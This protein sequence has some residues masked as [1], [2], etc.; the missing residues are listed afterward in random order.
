MLKAIMKEA[1]NLASLEEFRSSKEDADVLSS[2]G[3]FHMSDSAGD[4]TCCLTTLYPCLAVAL[5]LALPG[6]SGSS[7]AAAL[8]RLSVRYKHHLHSQ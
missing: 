8:G 7:P 2:P 1:Y 6:S 4:A 5:C 3:V